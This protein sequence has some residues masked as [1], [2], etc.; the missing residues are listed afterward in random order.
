MT[1]RSL[2]HALGSVS[3]RREGNETGNPYDGRPNSPERSEHGAGQIG[4]QVD[5]EDVSVYVY[6]AR[7]TKEG[8]GQCFTATLCK[9]SFETIPTWDPQG[10]SL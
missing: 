10:Q 5:L 7:M 3:V 2:Q 4:R 6:A 8:L 1:W 9:S